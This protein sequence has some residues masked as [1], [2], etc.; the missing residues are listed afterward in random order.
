MNIYEVVAIPVR[1]KC[2]LNGP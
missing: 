2:S 1:S